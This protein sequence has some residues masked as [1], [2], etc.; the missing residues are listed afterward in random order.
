MTF[1]NQKGD[2][3]D[4]VQV[5]SMGKLFLIARW[6]CLRPDDCVGLFIEDDECYH[7]QATFSGAWLKDLI[8]VAETAEVVVKHRGGR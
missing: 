4:D 2:P 3:I 8:D 6:T 7:L 5:I 1:Y